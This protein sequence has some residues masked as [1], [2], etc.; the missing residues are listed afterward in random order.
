MSTYDYDSMYNQERNNDI[1]DK[2]EA[3]VDSITSLFILEGKREKDV[4]KAVKE[5]RKAAKNLREGKPEKVFDV[6]RFEEYMMQHGD[7]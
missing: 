2:L 5:V 6:D 4:K 7:Y 3:Y 1:A